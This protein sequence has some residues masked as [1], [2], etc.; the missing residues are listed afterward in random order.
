MDVMTTDFFP[1]LLHHAFELQQKTFEHI[2]LV[3][4]S[5]FFASL[6]AIPLGVTITRLT[7][8]RNIFLN[9]GG[10]TQ[11][12][13]SL[14]ML[15]FLVPLFGLGFVPT[16]I[17][18]TFYATYPILRSTYTGLENVPPEC[19]EAAEVLGFTTI[20][21]IWFVELPLALPV[22]I[23]GL[24]VATASTIG[25]AT[26]AAFIGA[27][28]L[29]DFITQGLSLNNSSLILLGAIPTA[30]LAL[31]FDFGISQLE[32]LLHHRKLRSLKMSRLTK[33]FAIGLFLVV[34]AFS[35][36]SF[37][38]PS[39][40]T[41]VVASKNFTEQYIL[42]EIM[43]QLIEE[44]TDL[45]VQR[46]FNMGSTDIVHQAMLKG[47]VDMY[48]EYTGTAYLT[49]LNEE[50][51]Y[52]NIFDKVKTAY[53]DKFQVTWLKPFGYANAPTL[54][55]TKKLSD[56]HKI[57]TLSDLEPYAK[58]L[59]ISSTP[60]ALKRPDQ[61]PGLKKAYNLEFKKVMQVD[62]NL[63]F[64]AIEHQS[65]DVI[66]ASAT[67][68]KLKKHDLVTLKDDKHHYISYEAA[69]VIR[70]TVLIKYPEIEQALRPVLGS[71]SNEQMINLNYQVDVEGRSPADVAQEFL[72]NFPTR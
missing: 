34:T 43:A 26:V 49:V 54:T 38:T 61:L 56:I 29:G 62:P 15:G 31:G 53:E 58:N 12:L 14:A 17:T 47:K 19:R 66:V 64:S 16:I 48:P 18:L 11:T 22:I 6:I 7:Y 37:S 67:D 9:I 42:G 8:L 32:K 5:L 33:I 60:E 1:F 39:K 40:N 50:P 44:K 10:V 45:N 28:G 52:D 3:S 63:I 24:R 4:C 70:Q 57:H 68:G 27:G 13:P 72:K 23:S 36:F 30:L 46:A 59:V 69:P 65:A 35:I 2:Y 71:I 20:Q 25:I 21:K 41:V 55:I 51:T